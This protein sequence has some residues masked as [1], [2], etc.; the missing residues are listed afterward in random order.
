MMLIQFSDLFRSF[1]VFLVTCC[2][3]FWVDVRGFYWSPLL[4]TSQPLCVC[5]CVYVVCVCCC[6]G[7]L[8]MLL[9]LML[10]GLIQFNELFRSWCLVQF[11][12]VFDTV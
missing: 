12:V 8:L 11:I 9:G 3:K 10:L 5:M 1:G 4:A 7:L 2:C 6:R